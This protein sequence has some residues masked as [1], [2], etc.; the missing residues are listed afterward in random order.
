MRNYLYYAILIL[1]FS[2]SEVVRETEEDDTDLVIE[3]WFPNYPDKPFKDLV[4]N[5]ELTEAADLI[6]KEGFTQKNDNQH[7]IDKDNQVEVIFSES[8]KLAD[9]KV[10]FFAQKT[11]FYNEITALFDEKS[12]KTD[13]NNDFSVYLFETQNTFFDV[14]VFNFENM[15]RLHFKPTTSH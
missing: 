13:K 7:F 9:F 14:T 4:F 2:C 5:M 6:K 12:I 11:T 3:E 15:M 10:V 8:D 1:A